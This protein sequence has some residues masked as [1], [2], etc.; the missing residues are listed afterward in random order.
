MGTCLRCHASEPGISDYIGYC[1]D[2]IRGGQ[3]PGRQ[4][5]ETPQGIPPY[6]YKVKKDDTIT[7]FG[8]SDPQPANCIA[9]WLC[10]GATGTGYP[11]FTRTQGPETGCKN[12]AIYL[13]GCN[14]KCGFCQ[15][16]IH[17]IMLETGLPRFTTGEVLDWVDENT[18]CISFCGGTPDI[19]MKKVIHLARSFRLRHPGKILRICAETNLSAPIDELIE[20]SAIVKESGGGLNIG[21]K[22]GSEEV[23]RALTGFSNQINWSNFTTLYEK[24][25]PGIVVPFLRPALLLVPHYIDRREVETVCRKIANLDTNIPFKLISFLPRYRFAGSATTD[26]AFMAEAVKIAGASGLK[27]ISPSLAEIEQQKRLIR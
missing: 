18:T 2:C 5:L 6:I 20:F 23:H 1:V 4:N 24:Y 17:E 26:W 19:M 13:G 15:D 3:Q 8:F 9:S 10:P 22:A 21:L 27:N 7:A 14:Y 25:G 11:E 16:W 12:L